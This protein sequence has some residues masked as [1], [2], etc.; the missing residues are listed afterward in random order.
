MS[1]RRVAVTGAS[2]FIGG[3]LTAYLA[4]R[5][6]EVVRL[7][8]HQPTQP[9][10]RRW[11]PVRGG[12]DP[13]AIDDVDAIVHL[14][15]AGV[16]DH[17]WTPAFKELV[18]RSRVD[19]T[20]AVATAIAQ[21]GRPIRFVCGSAIGYY[22]DRGDEILTELS[23]PGTGFLAE[24]ARA[25]EGSAEPAIAAG[26]PVAFA[27]HGLVMGPGGGAFARLLRL[28]R[29]GLFGPLG[30]GRQYWSWI[31][32]ADSVRALSH[33]IDRPDLTGPVN[34]VGPD[35]RPQRVVASA[36]GHALHRPAMLPAPSVAL[37]VALGE[38]ADDIL[39]SQRVMPFALT[40]SG[41]TF[42]HSMLR[43]AA[44]WLVRESS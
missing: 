26:A 39:G 5:G 22:G 30:S 38:F 16:G 18:L 25:W 21:T 9:S 20:A 1:G 6:D 4:G 8:R 33:L 28:A 19:G 32:L 15:A 44:A 11:D 34:I 13:R 40:G 41:F 31:T 2:G 43:P 27:R 37:R 24:V 12:L 10:E 36:I 17:R 35:P 42:E 23:G 7:V 3:A 29:W 14:A